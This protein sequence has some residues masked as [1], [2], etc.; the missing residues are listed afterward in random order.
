MV[1][2]QK[3]IKNEEGNTVIS[4]DYEERKALCVLE[5]WKLGDP[6]GQ[7][8]L[9]GGESEL[10]MD[11]REQQYTCNSD[12]TLKT[13]VRQSHWIGIWMMAEYTS[14]ENMKFDALTSGIGTV[15]PEEKAK[16]QEV[17]KWPVI[18]VS[19]KLRLVHTA[20]CPTRDM[21]GHI[22]FK[23]LM[24]TRL[25]RGI[26]RKAAVST[27]ADWQ[28][29]TCC[30]GRQKDGLFWGGSRWPQRLG[31]PRWALPPVPLERSVASLAVLCKQMSRIDSL[32]MG[33]SLHPVLLQCGNGFM[34]WSPEAQTLLLQMISLLNMDFLHKKL[35]MHLFTTLRKHGSEARAYDEVLLLGKKEEMIF[36]VLEL[37]GSLPQLTAFPY[38]GNEYSEMYLLLFNM[39]KQLGARLS[40]E[41]VDNT[42]QHT[43]KKNALQKAAVG[44]DTGYKVAHNTRTRAKPMKITK[45]KRNSYQSCSNASVSQLHLEELTGNYVLMASREQTRNKSDKLKK[46]STGAGRPDINLVSGSPPKLPSAELH[47]FYNDTSDED[48]NIFVKVRQ[49]SH[50]RITTRDIQGLCT[51]FNSDLKRSQLSLLRTVFCGTLGFS[52]TF[53]WETEMAVNGS[54]TS[55]LYKSI[56]QTGCY[57]TLDVLY[58][59]TPTF[60]AEAVVPALGFL[61]PTNQPIEG[62]S[63]GAEIQVEHISCPEA[64]PL[65]CRGVSDDNDY[66]LW[67]S[68]ILLFFE[69]GVQEIQHMKQSSELIKLFHRILVFAKPREALPFPKTYLSNC[70]WM[71]KGREVP[72]PLWGSARL[73][74]LQQGTLEHFTQGNGGYHREKLPEAYVRSQQQLSLRPLDGNGAHKSTEES[75]T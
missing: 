50:D 40:A 71:H 47:N 68:S 8:H 41:R 34:S 59:H 54:D 10:Q 64:R 2:N 23:Y 31:I 70:C 33:H 14:H 27:A 39:T 16:K 6:K 17:K 9:K 21:F 19:V 65:L 3:R 42:C 43:L 24:F 49:A 57:S 30:P 35:C 67:L 56:R 15:F 72:P 20:A 25:M 61:S 5:K 75:P 37:T 51:R 13:Y 69:F 32:L 52:T 53:Q 36:S 66:C 38:T 18:L 26:I 11:E 62:A 63:E 45:S 44:H 60:T 22:V 74:G 12:E 46:N 73:S 48:L 1:T 29:V 55:Y 4:K 58:S 28:A 7:L